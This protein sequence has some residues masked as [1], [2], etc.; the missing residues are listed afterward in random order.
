MT[1][2]VNADA[3]PPPVYHYTNPEVTI[4]FSKPLEVSTQRQREIAD[5]IANNNTDTLT[6]PAL[7]SPE[8]IICTILGHKLTT[9]TVTATHHKVEQYSPRCLMELYDVTACSRC[10][11]TDVVLVSSFHIV[12][13][14]ED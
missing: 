7:A 9:S 12:C 11:Y 2:N 1:L 4:S 8:N 6:N 3:L 5:K 10:D 14:P 13:C